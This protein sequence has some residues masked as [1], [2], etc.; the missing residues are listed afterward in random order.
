[1]INKVKKVY[2]IFF[3]VVIFCLNTFIFSSYAENVN[4]NLNYGVNKVAKNDASL[5]VD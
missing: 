2:S 4:I 5:P 3:L 1:M